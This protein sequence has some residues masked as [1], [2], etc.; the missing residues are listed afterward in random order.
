MGQKALYSVVQK[1]Y[2]L[3]IAIISC[4]PCS[5]LTPISYGMQKDPQR[6]FF[7]GGGVHYNYRLYQIFTDF[8]LL[9]Y[10][11]KILYK[12]GPTTQKDR[13]LPSKLKIWCP[14]KKHHLMLKKL[15]EINGPGRVAKQYPE[16]HKTFPSKGSHFEIIFMAFGYHLQSRII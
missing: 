15:S 6:Y 13:S 1:M 7:G 2:M 10:T 9:N 11:F 16:Q 14:V 12:S 8:W 4:W 5:M 3:N